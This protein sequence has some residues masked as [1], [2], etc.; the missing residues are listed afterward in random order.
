MEFARAIAICEKKPKSKL[1]L[2]PMSPKVPCEGGCPPH[3]LNKAGSNSHAI[4]TTCM[5]CGT[6]TSTRRESPV[7]QV[8]YEDCQHVRTDN[9]GS[10]RRTHR[11]YCLDCCRTIDE[12]RKIFTRR[13]LHL[14]RMWR[15]PPVSSKTKGRLKGTE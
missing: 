8:A 13:V 4:K 3:A 15:G 5:L 12:T 1:S 14:H 7:P 2:F 11:V 10:V 6:K 9:R